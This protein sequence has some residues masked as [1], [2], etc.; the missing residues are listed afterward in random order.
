MGALVLN[1]K[2]T[3]IFKVFGEIGAPKTIKEIAG[4][5]FG[6]EARG[7]SWTRNGLRKLV[8]CKL[9]EKIGSGT[10]RVRRI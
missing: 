9:V 8:L 5:A 6:F 10:Y 3:L 7:N 4:L 1:E 2:E